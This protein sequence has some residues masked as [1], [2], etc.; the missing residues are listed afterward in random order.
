MAK[1]S[2]T[3]GNHLQ[4]LWNPIAPVIWAVVSFRC[5]PCQLLGSHRRWTLDRTRAAGEGN[6]P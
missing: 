5:L 3:P 2:R 6:F 1:F 4:P